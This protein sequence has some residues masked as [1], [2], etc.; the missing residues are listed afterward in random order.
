M[1][2]YIDDTAFLF[3]NPSFL[4]GLASAID[5]GGTLVEYNISRTTQEA[6]ARAIA[7]DW[8]I[9]GKDIL[10][11]LECSVEEIAEAA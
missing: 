11:A 6:D 3:A 7:A 10:T 2:S 1:G 4:Q 5:I 8:A 9:T